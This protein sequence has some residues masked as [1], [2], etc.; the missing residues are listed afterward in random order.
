MNDYTY[1]LTEHRKIYNVSV[2]NKFKKKNKRSA[3]ITDAE[4]YHDK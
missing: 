1:I 4:P 3:V 2:K